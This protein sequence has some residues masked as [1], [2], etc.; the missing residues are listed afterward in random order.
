MILQI[1]EQKAIQQ[2]N[3][4]NRAGFTLVEI[5]LVIAVIVMLV[6]LSVPSLRG[7][8][9][10]YHFSSTISSFEKTANYAR[11]IAILRGNPIRLVIEPL[12]FQY[13]LYELIL[14]EETQETEPAL[15]Q[16]ETWDKSIQFQ[17]QPSNEILFLPD[18]SHQSFKC[19]F[20]ASGY[21]K[22]SVSSRGTLGRFK[23]VEQAL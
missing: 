4:L 10:G 9:R 8:Y 7:T 2:K 22:G 21:R 1:G 11:E 20:E 19:E 23:R 3:K 16:T 6:G 12:T 18:G 5:I 14:D 17:C 13:Q 15:I